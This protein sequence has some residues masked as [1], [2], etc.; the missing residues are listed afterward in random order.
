MFVNIVFVS[1]CAI[2]L[3]SVELLRDEREGMLC[4]YIMA[5]SCSALEGY[6]ILLSKCSKAGPTMYM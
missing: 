6:L 2:S 5:D 4:M 1:D 3:S